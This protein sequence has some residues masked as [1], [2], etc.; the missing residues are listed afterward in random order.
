[1][2]KK[3]Y[4]TTAAAGFVVA[5]RRIP[6]V[7]VDG[8]N[9]APQV[10]FELELSDDEAAYEL[11]QGAIALKKVSEKGASKGIERGAE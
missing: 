6:A 2:E 8:D 4:V 7:Y 5:G 1:M 9:P 10:G 3:V 11:S